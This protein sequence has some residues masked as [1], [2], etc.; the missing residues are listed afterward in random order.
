MKQSLECKHAYLFKRSVCQ[1]L[2]TTNAFKGSCVS[3]M[4]QIF[5]SP[6]LVFDLTIHPGSSLSSYM[7][8]LTVLLYYILY[9][10]PDQY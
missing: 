5:Q 10:D 6:N 8:Y 1:T 3:L 9:Q 7:N 2:E 4:V